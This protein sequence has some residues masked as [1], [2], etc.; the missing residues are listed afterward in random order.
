MSKH[1]SSGI[2][3]CLR[4]WFYP[5]LS[6]SVALAIGLSSLPPAQAFSWQDLI[7]RGIQVIQLSTLSD[8]QEV[9]LG[10]Q[11]DGELVGGEIRLLRNREAT[12]YI[13]RIGQ[14]LAR[15][16]DRPDIPYTFQVVDDPEI[17]A[18][19]TMGGFVYVN[20]GLMLAADNEAELAS[21]IAHEI[22]HIVG[23][24]SVEQMRRMAIA[25]GVASVAGI[26]SNMAVQ[27][28]VELALRRPHSRSAEYEADRLGVEALVRAGYDGRAAVDF[29][30]KLLGGGSPPTFL[31]THPATGDRI[32]ALEREIDGTATASGAGMDTATY[33]ATLDHLFS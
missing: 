18:F 12:A 20:K 21:V 1:F 15:A 8:R 30:A 26:D 32:E 11:I 2:R 3:R 25:Q 14:Q 33:R 16:G 10:E 23:R 19:A 6:V 17:N 28:G 7:F 24:H 4:R 31:S 22:G 27:I 5:L 9:E 13:D 29:L